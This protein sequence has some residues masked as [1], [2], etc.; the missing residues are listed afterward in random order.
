MMNGLVCVECVEDYLV[1]VEDMVRSH[2]FH[3]ENG[4]QKE[5]GLC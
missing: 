3:M 5:D 1:P 2:R 4:A